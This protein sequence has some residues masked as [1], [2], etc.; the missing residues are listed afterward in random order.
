MS[1]IILTKIT[2]FLC[3]FSISVFPQIYH[4]DIS[5]EIDLGL[6]P[7]IERVIKDAQANNARAILL[8]VNTFGGRVDA[9]TQIKDLLFNIDSEIETIAFINKRAISAGAFISLSC[10]K[11]G[12]VPGST[13]G[14]A[15]VV[16]GQSG[17]K[18]SEKSISYFRTEMGATAER[19]DR[20]RDIAEGMVDSDIEIEGLIEKDKLITLTAE[21][22]I[23]WKMAD[24]IAPTLEAFLDTL[25][26]QDEK[27]VYTDENWAEQVVRFLTGSVIS[28][29]LISLGMLGLFFELQSPGWGVAGF[30]GLAC[31]LLFF[32][33]HY[34]INLAS[35]I[36]IILFLLGIVLLAVEVFV[37]PG[38]G[39]AGI[40]GILCIV[41]GLYLSL[42]GSW[43]V[44][45]VPDMTG[46]ALRIGG[47]L[48]L[49]IVG[50]IILGR[51][52]P[53][54]S[55]WNKISL[56]DE[57]KSDEGYVAAKDFSSYVGKVGTAM[58]PLR[59]AGVGEFGTE[60]LDVVTEGDFIEKNVPIKI[61][62]IE[63]YRLVVR[64]ESQ[65]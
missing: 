30:F 59:P 51:F 11:I 56:A 22:A 15:E 42:L 32:G 61:V 57:Q 60:R 18:A 13:M 53:R 20:N 25:G 62:K 14:A 48:T 58:T 35:G 44:I 39:I 45:T 40:S 29:L 27:I 10:L 36:E 63:G 23:E 28:S 2:L 17:E 31:L 46:A 65:R 5:G 64:E 41:A 21:D 3:F 47:A 50:A 4:I 7:Y 1:R 8:E 16:V 6:P 33:S 9:A 49:T 12:M 19:N 38:F 54:T 43:D 24:Y 34:I 37:I 26:L 52:V 55:F